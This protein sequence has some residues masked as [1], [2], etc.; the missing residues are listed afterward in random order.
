MYSYLSFML[1]ISVSPSRYA[2]IVHH[3]TSDAQLVVR[4]K[5]SSATREASSSAIDVAVDVE[6]V[7]I[8]TSAAQSNGGPPTIEANGI[9]PQLVLP[10]RYFT[11]SV[12]VSCFPLMYG[13]FRLQL[14]SKKLKLSMYINTFEVFC[15]GRAKSSRIILRSRYK[16]SC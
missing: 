11:V 7:P 2:P 4:W 1:T 3:K 8:C 9:L 6:L 14:P 13:F 10:T 15:A 12:Y 16:G 5:D